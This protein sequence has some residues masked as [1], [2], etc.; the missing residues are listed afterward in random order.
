[1]SNKRFYEYQQGQPIN[2]DT[3]DELEWMAHWD[4]VNR[5]IDAI[6]LLLPLV[7][8]NLAK[9]NR[10]TFESWIVNN[11][12]RL[13]RTHYAKI[14]SQLDQLQRAHHGVEHIEI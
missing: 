3:Y 6:D 8:P 12:L 9:Q 2:V 14:W 4:I 11:Q 5:T 7:D 13:M 1:M 10:S